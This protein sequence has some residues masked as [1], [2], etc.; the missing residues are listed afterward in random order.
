MKEKNFPLVVLEFELRASHL[1][2]RH[3][4]C[5]SNSASPFCDGFFQDRVS[6]TISPGWLQT[7]IL[8]ISASLV[9]RIIDLSH[10]CL[11]ENLFDL[12]KKK[13]LSS[14]QKF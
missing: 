7:A 1:L 9:A 10:Q 13:I 6:R 3:F 8:L 14:P 11:K 12:L 5:L 2:G 4:Y